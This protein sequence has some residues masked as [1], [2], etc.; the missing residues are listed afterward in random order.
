MIMK[1][2]TLYN[3]WLSTQL[4]TIYNI[5]FYKFGRS[6]EPQKSAN[7]TSYVSIEISPTIFLEAKC[8]IYFSTHS[9]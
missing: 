8:P 3:L 2:G 6:T 9:G 7:E 1:I 4:V 5:I